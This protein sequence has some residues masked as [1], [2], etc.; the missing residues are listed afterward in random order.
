M[1]QRSCHQLRRGSHLGRLVVRVAMHGGPQRGQRDFSIL[2]RTKRRLDPS[3]GLWCARRGRL[4][5]R[6]HRRH[7][8]KLWQLRSTS[9]GHLHGVRG[10]CCRLHR[11]T[12]R[13][14]PRHRSGGSGRS[15]DF[16]RVLL[17]HRGCGVDHQRNHRWFGHVRILHLQQPHG[18]HHPNRVD[19]LGW[20]P[21]LERVRH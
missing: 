7:G 10:G 6:C 12:R 18:V 16:G 21:N 20:R 4:L 8:T 11:F 15:V 5:P 14:S 9:R 1:H 13:G 3:R 2:Q 17:Q 19:G